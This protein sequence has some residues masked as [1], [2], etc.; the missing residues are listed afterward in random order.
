MGEQRQVGPG[1][2]DVAEACRKPLLEGSE[3]VASGEV[4]AAIR[5]EDAGE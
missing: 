4:E 3:L 5:G 2:A 1:V